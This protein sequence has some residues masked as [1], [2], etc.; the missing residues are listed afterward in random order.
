MSNYSNVTEQD[1][2]TLR[3]LAEQQKNRAL[4][5][6]NRISKQTHD[7]KIAEPLTPITKKLDEVKLST[8]KLRDVFKESQPETPQLAIENTPTHQPT[9]NIEGAINDVQ[10]ENTSKI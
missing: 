4:K 6:K 3:K 1:L 7:I 2:N 10:L 8:Q 5:I 9:E